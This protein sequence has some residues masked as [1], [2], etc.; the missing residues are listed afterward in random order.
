[1]NEI[2]SFLSDNKADLYKSILEEFLIDVRIENIADTDIVYKM[3]ELALK[4]NIYL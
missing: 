3:K 2:I 1:M 4:N